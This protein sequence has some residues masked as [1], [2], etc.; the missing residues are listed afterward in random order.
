MEHSDRRVMGRRESDLLFATR[1]RQHDQLFEMGQTITSQLHFEDLFELII[2]QANA[3]MG[4]ERSTV[5]LHDR[6][7]DVLWSLVA[8]DVT[9]KIEVR[10]DQ[11]IAG[12]VF[13]RREAFADPGISLGGIT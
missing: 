12:W 1:L 11:G 3:I 2:E 4:C 8:T 10:S 9:K 7:R 5:F 13:T 6:D